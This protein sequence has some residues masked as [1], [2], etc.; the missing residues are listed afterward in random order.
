M[1]V[2][3]NGKFVDAPTINSLDKIR[4]QVLKEKESFL[5]QKEITNEELLKAWLMQGTFKHSLG[6]IEIKKIDSFNFEVKAESRKLANF[7]ES[8]RESILQHFQLY[9]KNRF[10]SFVTDFYETPF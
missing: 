5:I 1:Y 6:Q 3:P 7:I 10:L 8:K 2:L 4:Q 9:F